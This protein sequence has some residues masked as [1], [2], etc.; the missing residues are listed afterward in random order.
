MKISTYILNNWAVLPKSYFN[1][2]EVVIFSE[3]ENENHGWGHHYYKG[4]GV[5]KSGKIVECSS[6]GC[7]CSGSV[8][9]DINNSEPD[10]DNPESID[11]K[12]LEVKFDDY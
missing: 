9:V 5:S 2:E 8:R 3:K 7:S 10:V 4:Y 12:S 6:S 11:F 1:G